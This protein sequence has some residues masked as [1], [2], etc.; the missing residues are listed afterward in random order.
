[1]IGQRK[2][3]RYLTDL[4]ATDML[5]RFCILTGERGSGKK[6][7]CKWLAEQLRC[8]IMMCD[9]GVDSV[10]EVIE[11]AYTITSPVL[12]VFADADNMSIG[13]K[14]ALLKITEESPHNARFIMTLTDVENTLSTIRSRAFILHMDMYSDEE[15]IKYYHLTYGKGDE[16]TMQSYCTTLGDVDLLCSYNAK[17]FA[18]YVVTVVDN[19]DKVSGSNSFK[20]GQRL[21]LGTDENKY[22]LA[23]FWKAFRVECVRRLD[24]HPFKYGHGVSITCKYLDDL[25][26]AGINKQ[27]CFDNWLLDIRESWMSYAE[28]NQT[29]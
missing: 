7:L 20:I 21:D 26:L 18:D 11:H 5:P 16:S 15:I 19:I 29:E 14:N 9:S 25:R 1:M 4:I 10:R 2:I 6:L 13:A 27:M 24:K 22:D 17:E 28:D 8:P 3:Q 23:L 12:Y